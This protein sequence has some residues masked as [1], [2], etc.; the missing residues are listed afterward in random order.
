ME[1]TIRG[2]EL[3]TDDFTLDN[4][5]ISKNSVPIERT[6]VVPPGRHSVRFTATPPAS[7]ASNDPR[8]MLF[9]IDQ[10]KLE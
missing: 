4:S 3:W 8:G 5:P 9:F 6:F 10:M 1:L 2:G 7:H